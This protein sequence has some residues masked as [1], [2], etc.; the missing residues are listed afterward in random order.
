MKNSHTHHTVDIKEYYI[1]KRNK[2]MMYMNV[3]LRTHNP[4]L[5]TLLSSNVSS[6][7]YIKNNSTSISKTT[8]HLISP[9]SLYIFYDQYQ[10]SL[11]TY[12][13][14]LKLPLSLHCYPPTLTRQTNKN[15]HLQHHCR[16]Q[17][18]VMLTRLK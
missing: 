9:L 6:L 1:P 14:P 3:E 11:H 7:S 12:F 5:E 13:H 15:N 4:Q 16:H 18:R 2:G 8:S 10:C 17:N